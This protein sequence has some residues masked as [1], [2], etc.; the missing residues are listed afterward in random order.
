MKKQI[1]LGLSLDDDATFSNFYGGDNLV[2]VATLETVATKESSEQFIYIYGNE[3]VGRSHLLQACCHATDAK[4]FRCFYLPL[5]EYAQLNTEILEGLETLDLVCID[6]IDAIF[7]RVDWEEA[8][9]HFYNKARDHYCRLIVVGQEVPAQSKRCQLNDLRSRLSWGPVFH[10]K[11]LQDL[12]KVLALQ[13]RA[14][15]R[16]LRLPL[17]VGKYLLTHFPRNMA[18]L[19]AALE[20]L[21]KASL[22]EKR[23]LT[24]PFVKKVLS[25]Q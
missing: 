12:Q 24:I 19:F 5:E 9:L 17:E 22:V 20:L 21:D 11:P 2:A 15:N 16:G 1:P 8:L 14:A 7:G 4:K 18:K 3:G 6:N 10:I 13:M 25:R 23:K